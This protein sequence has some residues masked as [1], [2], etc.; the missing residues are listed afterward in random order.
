MAIINARE[1]KTKIESGLIVEAAPLKYAREA[2]S[3]PCIVSDRR[4]NL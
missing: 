3:K 1:C 4:F 2:Q